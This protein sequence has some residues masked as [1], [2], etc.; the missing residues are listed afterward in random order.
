MEN[1]LETSKRT[2]IQPKLQETSP[3][4][5]VG[6][7]KKGGWCIRFESEPLRGI[8]KE[9]KVCKGELSPCGVNCSI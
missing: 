2:S 7:K 4:N 5:Q 1:K 3:C 8:Y 9:E 6:Q